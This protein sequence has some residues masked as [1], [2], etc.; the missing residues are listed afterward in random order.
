MRQLTRITFAMLAVAL[1]VGLLS[2]QDQPPKIKGTLPLN[3]GKHGLSDD[4]KKKVYDIRAIP[5][6]DVTAAE[7][8]R[9]FVLNMRRRDRRISW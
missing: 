7:Q 5:D 8:M 2:A 3:W 4:Q 6:I 1:V 9:T